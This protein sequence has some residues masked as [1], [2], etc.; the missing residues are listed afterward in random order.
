MRPVLAGLIL[1]LAAFQ[2][3]AAEFLSLDFTRE[4]GGRYRLVS[5]IRMDA[6]A[7]GVFEV[8]SD[9]EGFPRL[10]S[11]FEEGRVLEPVSNGRG[12]VYL[13]MKGC[14]LFFCRQVELVEILQ[15]DPPREII[16]V[17]DPDRSDLDFGRA[18]WSVV[19]EGSGSLVRY[20]LEMDPDFWIPPLIGPLVVEA[21]L[22]SRGLRAAR[23]IEALASGREIPADI[24]VKRS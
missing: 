9:Y 2:V 12:L 22:R 23:R 1:G 3:E 20:E 4:G 16:A 18:V 8:L 17:I 15:V 10:S 21:A 11:V 19:S 14:V 6:P 24:A 7:D 13:R 5:E